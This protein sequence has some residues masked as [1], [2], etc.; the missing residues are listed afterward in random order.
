[1][2]DDDIKKIE[3]DL[4]NAV[5]ALQISVM[6]LSSAVSK[7]PRYEKPKLVVDN[8]SKDN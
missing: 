2:L 1:M 3:T 6:A 4:A 5:K 7:M 8:V